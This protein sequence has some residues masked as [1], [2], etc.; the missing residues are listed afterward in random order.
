MCINVFKFPYKWWE[1]SSRSSLRGQAQGA[2]PGAGRAAGKDGKGKS[3]ARSKGAR[4]QTLVT[5]DAND[6]FVFPSL[7]REGYCFFNKALNRHVT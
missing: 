2:A 4:D 7:K 1:K 5:C 6:D 3:D